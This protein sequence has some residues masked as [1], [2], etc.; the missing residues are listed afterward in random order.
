MVIFSIYSI[1]NEKRYPI[2][3]VADVSLR[4]NGKLKWANFVLIDSR[5]ILRVFGGA[6]HMEHSSLSSVAISP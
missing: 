1:Q 6:V 2:N 3:F 5:L 4:I